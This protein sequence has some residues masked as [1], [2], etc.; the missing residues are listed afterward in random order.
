MSYH[1]GIALN[2]GSRSQLASPKLQISNPLKH[3][4]ATRNCLTGYVFGP[5]GPRL[6]SVFG[7]MYRVHWRKTIFRFSLKATPCNR[8]FSSLHHAARLPFSSPSKA[9]HLSWC[10]TYKDGAKASIKGYRAFLGLTLAMSASSVNTRHASTVK[11]SFRV[12][13]IVYDITIYIYIY[14]YPNK[15]I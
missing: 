8:L 4:Q 6:W 13:M 1:C 2:V 14:I 3:S 9:L 7:C 10:C 15:Y 12:H 11:L 5:Q